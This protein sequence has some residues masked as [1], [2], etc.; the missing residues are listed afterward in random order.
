MAEGLRIFSASGLFSGIARNLV[1]AAIIQL[2]HGDPELGARIAGA[3]HELAREHQVM[4]APVKVL[5]LPDPADL[6]AERFGSVRSE[7]LLAAGAARPLA[8]TIDEVLAAAPPVA[9]AF[10]AV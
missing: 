7:E 5:H 4:L 1:M 3:A 8:E 2:V 9:V 6:S 10:E